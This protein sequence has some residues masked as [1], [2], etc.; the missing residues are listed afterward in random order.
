MEA[1]FLPINPQLP[2]WFGSLQKIKYVRTVVTTAAYVVSLFRQVPRYDVIHAFSASYWSFILAPA[3]AILASRLYRRSSVLNYRSGEADDHLTRWPL[4]TKPILRQTTRI[5]VPSGYLVD[6][7]GRFGWPAQAIPN[8][9]DF[10]R[11]RF[12]LRNPLRP[13]FLS[14]RNFEV[15]YNV[16]CI[17]RAF[18][19]LKDRY[20]EARLLVAGDGPEGPALHRLT[21]GLGLSGVEFLGRVEPHRMPDLIDKA[22]IYLNMPN[23]DNM[24]TS[25]LEAFAAGLPVVSSDAGGIPWIVDH[26]RTGLLVPRDDDDALASAASSLLENP[27]LAGSLTA[28][29]RQQVEI[30]R[31]ESVRNQWVDLYTSLT[32]NRSAC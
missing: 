32:G 12:R 14:N 20:P 10:S 4:S 8:C 7:F 19:R 25:I 22:D 11:L 16:A 28:A 26:G 15:H 18:A 23:L 29:A 5:V 30:Y 13:V 6:V 1:D 9:P 3:P 17:L 27:A 2:G 31:W 24:P 21:A